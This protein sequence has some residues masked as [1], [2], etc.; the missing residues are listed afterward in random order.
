MVINENGIYEFAD[1]SS[2][3]SNITY[4][5]VIYAALTYPFWCSSP[6]TATAVR[7]GRQRY[8]L[9]EGVTLVDRIAPEV[10][11]AQLQP[12]ATPGLIWV[13]LFY[14]YKEY[15]TDKGVT[16]WLCKEKYTPLTTYPWRFYFGDPFELRMHITGAPTA[17]KVKEYA[18]G[19]ASYYGVPVF[20]GC[21]DYYVW[22]YG[23][24]GQCYCLPFSVVDTEYS[25]KA[26][27]TRA[28]A[29]PVYIGQYNNF[30]QTINYSTIR[31][32]KSLRLRCS[33]PLSDDDYQTAATIAASPYYYYADSSLSTDMKRCY[34]ED[35]S[36]AWETGNGDKTI[37]MTIKQYE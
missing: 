25:G 7:F 6:T 20:S 37:E 18:Q 11:L 3:G 31:P 36:T 28:T 1:D 17:A 21:F 12:V 23:V 34:V 29:I 16:L 19:Y 5:S 26:D 2:T 30:G 15:D 24:A 35:F 14:I 10:G 4:T 22:W 9:E 33:V 13:D 27:T 8:V 32:S